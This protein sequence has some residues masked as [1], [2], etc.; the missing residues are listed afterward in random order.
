MRVVGLL[1]S[2][3]AVAATLA[4]GGGEETPQATGSP[5]GTDAAAC[6]TEDADLIKSDLDPIIERFDDANARGESTSRIALSPVIGEMQEIRRDLG[7][8]DLPPCAGKATAL[9]REY[10][11]KVIE[12][13]LAFLGDE[14]DSTVQSLF[15]YAVRAQ[16]SSVKELAVIYSKAEGQ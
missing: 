5:S 11:D 12:A 7:T 2:S 9:S 15:E 8:L 14:P 10:M 4:C 3:T 6:S 16:D 1:L 13:Y